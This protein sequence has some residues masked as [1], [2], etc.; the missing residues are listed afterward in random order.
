MK[1]QCGPKASP[2][3]RARSA[4]PQCHSEVPSWLL[5]QGPGAAVPCLECAPTRGPRGSLLSS[6]GPVCPCHLL[7]GETATLPSSLPLYPAQFPTR[8]KPPP[9]LLCVYHLATGAISPGRKGPQLPPV[10]RTKLCT[11]LGLSK[12]EVSECLSLESWDL[13]PKG[14]APP[15]TEEGLAGVPREGDPGHRHTWLIAQD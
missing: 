4:E 14:S 1:R 12:P 11:A 10:P 2:G 7:G 13:A 9:D 5:P 6:L 15:G 3:A 8:K